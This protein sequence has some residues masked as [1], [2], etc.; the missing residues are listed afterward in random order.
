MKAVLDEIARM[1]KPIKDP[2]EIRQVATIASNSDHEIGD[3]IAKAFENYGSKKFR[4]G[5][6]PRIA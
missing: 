2:N 6:R 3:L 4:F 5:S 1:A